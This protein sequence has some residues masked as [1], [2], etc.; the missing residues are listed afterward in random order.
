MAKK[1]AKSGIGR[2]ENVTVE[3]FT[4]A[5]KSV[6][7]WVNADDGVAEG[8]FVAVNALGCDALAETLRRVYWGVGEDK[9]RK[10]QEIIEMSLDPDSRCPK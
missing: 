10:L 7:N 4:N 2:D 3:E 8:E 6:A 9:L 5:M 1:R